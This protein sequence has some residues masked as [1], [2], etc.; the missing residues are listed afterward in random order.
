ME[1]DDLIRVIV[2]QNEDYKTML[3]WAISGI[4]SILVIFLAANFFVM[5]KLRKKEIEKVKQEIITDLKEDDLKQIKSELSSETKSLTRNE[6][7]SVWYSIYNLQN[8]VEDKNTEIT[9]LKI[10][11]KF[12]KG[13][14]HVQQGVYANAYKSYLSALR[15][16]LEFKQCG[17]VD[18]LLQKVEE[19]VDNVDNLLVGEKSEFSSVAKLLNSEHEEQAKKIQGKLNQL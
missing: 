2:E 7:S 10:D 14:L 1:I 6:L 3:Q 17:L 12:L 18:V 13:D 9:S 15:N 11:L 16:C 5:Q 4:I 19:S 8:T